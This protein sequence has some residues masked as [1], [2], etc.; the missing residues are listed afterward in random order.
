MSSCVLILCR[1]GDQHA[2]AV[3]EALT[4][5]GGRSVIYHLTDFPH[6][7]GETVALSSDAASVRLGGIDLDREQIDVVWFRRP[8]FS[9]DTESCIRLIAGTL[10]TSATCFAR[11]CITQSGPR[12]SG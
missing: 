12:P 9:L 11:A 8:A 7:S 6:R 2:Y 5:K 10:K 1:P 3:S 4:L